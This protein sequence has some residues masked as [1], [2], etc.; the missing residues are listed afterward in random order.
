MP[1]NKQ[2]LVIGSKQILGSRIGQF[3]LVILAILIA[4]WFGTCN[5]EDSWKKKYEEYRADAQQVATQFVDSTR[6][7]VD[8]LMHESD[9]LKVDNIKI[10][11]NI[12]ALD[13]TNKKLR[14][15]LK[16]IKPI[17]PGELPPVCNVCM[18]RLDSA[19]VEIAKRDSIIANRDLVIIKKDS[20]IS[21][22]EARILL[23][24]GAL[25][26]EKFTTDSLKLTILNM[27]KAPPTPRL[28]GLFKLGPTESF[29]I[30]AAGTAITIA[31]VSK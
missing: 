16:I 13:K 23:L 11:E 31:A 3:G 20:T 21:N 15:S 6:A 17:R 25:V 19:I 27:P 5:N 10:R 24:E 4:F 7:V 1:L 30:G 9:L 12:A 14:D 18:V 29:L 28:L 2:N 8:S 22:N 26:T